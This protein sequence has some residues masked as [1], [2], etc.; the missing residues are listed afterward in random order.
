MQRIIDI[1]IHMSGWFLGT[2]PE[3]GTIG[4]QAIDGVVVHEL[5]DATGKHVYGIHVY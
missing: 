4:G 1:K 5:L 3:E 2:G